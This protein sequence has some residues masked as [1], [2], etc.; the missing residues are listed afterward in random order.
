MMLQAGRRYLVG[1]EEGKFGYEWQVI[2]IRILE[3]SPS[4]NFIKIEVHLPL[5][6]KEART[7]TGATYLMWTKMKEYEP[8]EDLGEIPKDEK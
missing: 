2:E 6:G 3:V 5:T 8:L 4:G 1:T 7:V